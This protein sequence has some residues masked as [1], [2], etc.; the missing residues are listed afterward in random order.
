MFL[1]IDIDNFKRVNDTYGHQ[2]GDE[3]LV[4]IGSQLQ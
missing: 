2:V 4:Q 1:L 3:V